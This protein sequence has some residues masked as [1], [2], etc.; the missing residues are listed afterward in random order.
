MN[1]LFLEPLVI[2]GLSHSVNL[3][4]LFLQEYNLKMICTEQE[5]VLMPV[6]CGST[7]RVRLRDRGCHIFLSKKSE[8]V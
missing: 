3:G 7:S 8:T 6:K 2:Q 4:M 1:N 5:V